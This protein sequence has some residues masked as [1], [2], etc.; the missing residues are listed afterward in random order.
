[1]IQNLKNKIESRKILKINFIGDV[2]IALG[3]DRIYLE[4]L[5]YFLNKLDFIESKI[6]SQFLGSSVSDI[7]IFKKGSNFNN[8]FLKLKKEALLG[9]IH[10]TEK[11]K[12]LRMFDFAIVGSVEEKAYYSK[13]LKC[14]VFPQIEMIDSKYIKNYDKRPNKVICYHGN[15]VH[16]DL[17]HI[18]LEK[19][20]L[21]LVSQGYSFKAIYNH[22]GL[23][24]CK[25][26]FITDHIQWKSESWLKEIANSTVGICPASHYSG[27]IKEKVSKFIL[28]FGNMHSNLTY[29]DFIFKHKNTLNAGRS[30][31]FHQLKIP[32]AAEIASCHHHVMG[33]E[34]AGLVCFS[35][36]SWYEAILKLS[37]DKLFSNQIAEK[38]Y[39]SVNELYDPAKWTKKFIDSLI[40]WVINY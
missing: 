20:L 16:L 38:A 27:S 21:R 35:E 24:K 3:S 8:N 26:K 30:F 10:P 31:V 7:L 17:I 2:N 1:M 13:Y 37:Q 11:T 19:A 12:N 18:N 22:I 25:K 5:N 4:N 9:I 28:N 39:Y 29:S 33:D 15:K 14:F 34:S 36:N 23:G 32:V 40:E 6:D